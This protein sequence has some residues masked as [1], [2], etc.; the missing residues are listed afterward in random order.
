MSMLASLLLLIVSAALVAL[1]SCLTPPSWSPYA[2]GGAIGVLSWLAFLSSDRGLGASTA[3][4]RL[5][6]LIAR[7]F[8]RRA[9]EQNECY[10]DV[11]V[12]VDWQ[13]ML[14]LGVFLGA[15]VSALTSGAFAPRWVPS[16]WHG[17]FGGAIAP[18]LLVAF[19]GGVLIAFGARWAGGC[20]SG[21]GITGTL[22]MSV[23]GWL[24]AI[25]FFVGGIATA[26]LIYALGGAPQ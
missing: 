21:Q 2:A 26:M 17:S 11:G 3:Y 1:L 12:K 8:A 23:A 22:Q 5:S 16:L 24:A 4:V 14:L 25:C 18:R 9:V 15:L 10:R 19:V 6:G 7:P 20:T 13:I